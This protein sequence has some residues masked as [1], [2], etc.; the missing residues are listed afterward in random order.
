MTSFTPL[1][2]AIRH[3]LDQ[4]SYSIRALERAAGLPVNA[5]RNILNGTSRNPSLLVL[6]A[7]SEALECSIDTFFPPLAQSRE[8]VLGQEFDFDLYTECMNLLKTTLSQEKLTVPPEQVHCLLW[9]LYVYTF[10]PTSPRSP[11]DFCHWLLRRD[12]LD[13]PNSVQA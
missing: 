11:T 10:D 8:S 2:R 7:L 12:F 9:D 4:K 1:Q 6:S 5:V 3:G 13:G